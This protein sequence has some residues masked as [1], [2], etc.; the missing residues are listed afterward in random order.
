MAYCV[1]KVKAALVMEDGR[2]SPLVIS[3]QI[4]L[5]IT[6]TSPPRATTNL[7]N[8]KMS[9]TCLAII[10][11]R[12]TGVPVKVEKGEGGRRADE[13]KRQSVNKRYFEKIIS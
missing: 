1:R 3:L 5:L 8:S 4:F 2:L 11:I 10:G 12:L 6:S 7:Y 9:S 13:N